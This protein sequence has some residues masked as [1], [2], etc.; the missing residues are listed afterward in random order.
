ME[1]PD[2]VGFLAYFKIESFTGLGL[3]IYREKAYFCSNRTR[4]ASDLG[5]WKE[6]LRFSW[7]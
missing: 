4:R 5:R 7:L 2:E 1:E 3:D 6:K